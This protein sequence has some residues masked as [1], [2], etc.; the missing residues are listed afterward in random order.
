MNP[1]PHPKF[2]DV[3]YFPNQCT[4]LDKPLEKS[5]VGKEVKVLPEQLPRTIPPG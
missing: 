5:E 4:R 3:T 1:V 2:H